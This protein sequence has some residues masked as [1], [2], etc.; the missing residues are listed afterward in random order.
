MLAFTSGISVLA[1]L[2]LGFAPAW[3]LART[4]INEA[5]KQGTSH[6]VASGK[7][8][9]MRSALVV[10]EIAL[11]VVLLSGAGLLMRS[12]AGLHNVALG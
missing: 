12:F 1:S 10:G 9:R 4:D 6:A 8:R 7:A 3:Q 11:A 5:L 2:L